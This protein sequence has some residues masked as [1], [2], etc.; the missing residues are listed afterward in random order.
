MSF[1]IYYM[2]SY[3]ILTNKKVVN[4]NL[5]QEVFKILGLNQ[6]N[7]FLNIINSLSNNQQTEQ[8]TIQQN[9]NYYQLPTYEYT[10]QQQTINMPQPTEQNNGMDIQSLLKIIATI[11]QIFG[12][13]KQKPVEDSTE[14]IIYKNEDTQSKI[15]H[16][17][18]IN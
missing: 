12:N 14:K 13:K 17:T 3:I 7:A 10:Q 8:H 18:R 2:N 9:T 15:Q 5:L 16:L 6:P 11:L 4:M 1:T